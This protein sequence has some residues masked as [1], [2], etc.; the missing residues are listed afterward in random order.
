[1]FIRA[2][3][4]NVAQM[5]LG[6]GCKWKESV[7]VGE[8]V[9]RGTCLQPCSPCPQCNPLRSFSL[10]TPPNSPCFTHTPMLHPYPNEPPSP[11]SKTDQIC[12]DWSRFPIL[13]KA[14]SHFNDIIKGP[15]QKDE[16]YFFVFPS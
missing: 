12:F 7:H 2:M 4:M 6:V 8:G 13:F 15:R 16:S 10:T 5:G 9:C 3:R 1:M 14:V 11:V